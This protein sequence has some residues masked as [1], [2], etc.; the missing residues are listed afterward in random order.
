MPHIK[1]LLTEGYIPFFSLPVYLGS[2]CPKLHKMSN[3]LYVVNL[4]LDQ[5]PSGHRYFQ[6]HHKITFFFHGFPHLTQTPSQQCLPLL[7]KAEYVA[8]Q[9][10]PFSDIFTGKLCY[11]HLHRK[12]RDQLRVG[13]SMCCCFLWDEA[14]CFQA[15]KP[16]TSVYTGWA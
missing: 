7:T 14:T 3:I 9:G 10:L 15:L 12:Q 4:L 8:P 16:L 6:W 13:C 11:H 5:S 1:I 2:K